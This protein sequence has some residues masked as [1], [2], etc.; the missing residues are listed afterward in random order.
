MK[1]YQDNSKVMNEGAAELTLL[2]NLFNHYLIKFA[3]RSISQ[4]EEH[5]L[6]AALALEASGEID[7]ATLD[8]FLD[9]KGIERRPVVS[10][11]SYSSSNDGCG[12]GSYTRG[13]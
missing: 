8:E 7:K 13:C 6:T 9:D 4:T 11:R 1:K 12:H 3:N 5:F 10:R 2:D